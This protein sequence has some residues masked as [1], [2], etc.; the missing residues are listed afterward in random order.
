MSRRPVIEWQ[1]ELLLAMIFDYLVAS[2]CRPGLAR[3][4][5]NLIQISVSASDVVADRVEAFVSRMLTSVSHQVS[6]AIASR[7]VN[8]VL[9]DREHKSDFALIPEP[10]KQLGNKLKTVAKTLDDAG[11]FQMPAPGES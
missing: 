7:P 4:L 9:R 10:Q 1:L 8:Q 11:A 6:S 5:C 2:G 3:L